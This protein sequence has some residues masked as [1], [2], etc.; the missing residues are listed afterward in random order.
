MSCES[1]CTQWRGPW[2]TWPTC[3]CVQSMHVVEEFVITMGFDKVCEILCVCGCGWCGRKGRSAKYFKTPTKRLLVKLREVQ[4]FPNTSKM[5][6]YDETI[7][8]TQVYDLTPTTLPTASQLNTN[9]A[10]SFYQLRQFNS[11]VKYLDKSFFPVTIRN[12]TSHRLKVCGNQIRQLQIEWK[13]KLQRGSENINDLA[14]GV[15]RKVGV[16]GGVGKRKKV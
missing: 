9:C 13:K 11:F 1:W 8:T 12:R 16:G 3:G 10:I 14:L 7:I 4:A 15:G 2:P 6:K 5:S